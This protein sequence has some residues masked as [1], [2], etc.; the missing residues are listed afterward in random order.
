MDILLIIINFALLF[1]IKKQYTHI[2]I[3]S[4][5]IEGIEMEHKNIIKN[6][7]SKDNVII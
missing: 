4:D 3:I 1:L 7:D 5:K 6:V 2:K